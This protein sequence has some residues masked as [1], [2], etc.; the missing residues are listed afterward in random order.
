MSRETEI[1]EIERHRTEI[2]DEVSKRDGF[3]TRIDGGV[4]CPYC[5]TSF[6]STIKTEVLD[7]VLRDRAEGKAKASWE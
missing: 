5:Y 7:E 1:K 3:L 4:T 6:A 2:F